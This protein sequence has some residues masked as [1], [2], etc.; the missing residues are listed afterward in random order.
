[1][2]ITMIVAAGL[3]A[4]FG[5]SSEI[6]AYMIGAAVVSAISVEDNHQIQVSYSKSC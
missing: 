2:C 6:A 5:P 1:M 4:N 3:K